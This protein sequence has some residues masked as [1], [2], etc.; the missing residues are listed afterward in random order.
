MRWLELSVETSGEFVEPVVHL[1]SKYCEGPPVIELS[2][3][4]NPDE[5]EPPPPPGSPVSVRGYV[6]LDATAD[7]RRAGID[8]GLRLLR[9]VG[10]VSTIAE[11]E[12]NERVWLAQE[13]EPVRVGRRLLI[14]PTSRPS[15]AGPGDVVI[16]LEPGIA[17]GTGHHPTTAMCLEWLESRITPH[18]QF[19]DVGCG[20]G[21][22]AI[23]ALKLRARRAV[24]LDVD[25]QAVSAT[26]DNLRRAGVS[27]RAAALHGSLPHPD[28]YA[29]VWDTVAANIS[30]AALCEL[31]PHLVASLT[32]PGALIASGLLA[33]RRKEVAAA[34]T[35]TGGIV[36]SERSRGDWV[37]L[38][39]SRVDQA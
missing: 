27:D 9:Y 37:A 31:A 38:E 4:F 19:L 6:R 2:G 32:G 3:G 11:K 17:F 22:L 26:A 14:S 34:F 35:A 12:I 13:F 8:V 5:G 20:S 10:Q 21:I 23:A 1:F 36:T 25:E 24:C 16:P 29:G 39:V 7:S 18:A 28:V 15:C 30:A 33:E